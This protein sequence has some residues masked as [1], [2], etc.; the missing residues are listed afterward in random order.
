MS[1]FNRIGTRWTGGDYRL[2]TD[3]L[4]NEWGFKG[5]VLCD[6]N[7]IPSYMIS[8][9]MAYAGGDINL[10]TQPVS[11]VDESS[12]SDVIVLRKCI[13]NILYAVV[14]SNAM[15]GVVV[16]YKLPYWV[17]CVIIIDAVVVAT[18]AVWGFF[19]IHR[20]LKPE[21]VAKDK[22]KKKN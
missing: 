7:T 6:F 9:Q 4:R 10:A 13:K 22:E 20:A 2:L 18:I 1:S 14:N 19:V 16:G 8:R 21:P 17:I 3:I 15:N 12:V 11:W 5:V